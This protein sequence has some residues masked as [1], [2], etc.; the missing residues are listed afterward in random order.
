MNYRTYTYPDGHTEFVPMS[1]EEASEQ[2]LAMKAAGELAL[3]E[4]GMIECEMLD[5]AIAGR[6]DADIAGQAAA[7]IEDQEPE[8]E[9]EH[10]TQEQRHVWA[11]ARTAHAL[12]SGAP[13][14]YLYDEL[15]NLEDNVYMDLILVTWRGQEI[16][17]PVPIVIDMIHPDS[18]TWYGTG[19]TVADLIGYPPTEYR[20]REYE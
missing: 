1:D 9:P 6:L 10:P 2:L 19:Q 20:E 14:V 18:Y 5:P 11:N 12:L 8:P 3:S 7:Q 17:C 4:D 16:V 15:L 13:Y